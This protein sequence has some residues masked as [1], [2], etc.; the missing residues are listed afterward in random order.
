M[1]RD[2]P[3]DWAGVGTAT[4]LVVWPR[5]PDMVKKDIEI[6]GY[7]E[8]NLPETDPNYY[9]GVLPNENPDA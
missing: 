3:G 6:K 1:L 2:L 7:K 5:D 4:H 8:A 9:G